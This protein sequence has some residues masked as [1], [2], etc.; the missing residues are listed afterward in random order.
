MNG[1]PSKRR[2]VQSPLPPVTLPSSGLSREAVEYHDQKKHFVESLNEL[3][4]G[5][6]T[7]AGQSN[8]GSTTQCTRCGDVGHWFIQVELSKAEVLKYGTIELELG[9]TCSP[10]LIKLAVEM[11]NRHGLLTTFS[12]ME[13]TCVMCGK[14]DRLG[15][16]ANGVANPQE[17]DM[18]VKCSTCGLGG[19]VKVDFGGPCQT[20][21]SERRRK[22]RA[23]M[24]ASVKTQEDRESEREVKMDE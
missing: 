7:V 23:H 14:S 12:K 16:L 8:P 15:R 11:A 22:T 6:L 20:W 3:Y 13:L 4:T 24:S 5:L 21:L 18:A 17:H 19:R 10:C 9:L 2:A 1:R